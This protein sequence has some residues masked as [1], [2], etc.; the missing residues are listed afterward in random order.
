MTEEDTVLEPIPFSLPFMFHNAK[1]ILLEESLNERHP[2]YIRQAF[3]ELGYC[4]EV[5]D[6]KYDFDSINEQNFGMASTK[7][8]VVKLSENIHYL[9]AISRFFRANLKQ[10]IL[11][12]LMI[13]AN[14]CYIIMHYQGIRQN[15]DYMDL[16]DARQNN[17]REVLKNLRQDLMRN[18]GLSNLVDYEI[19][20][21]SKGEI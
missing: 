1:E 15:A 3:Y 8:Q 5:V 18:Y 11:D 21:D 17:L 16:I 7:E 19:E 10:E 4:D 14:W 9:I 20:T 12:S 6:R 2:T 13:I